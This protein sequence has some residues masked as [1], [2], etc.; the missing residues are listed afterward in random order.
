MLRRNTATYE[1][2]RRVETMKP[3]FRGLGN[4]LRNGFALLRKAFARPGGNLDRD[5]D[6]GRDLKSQ[7]MC[8]SC[9]LITSSYKACCLECGKTLKPA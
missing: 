8:P 7:R 5:P 6:L 9:G 2:V 1:K 3:V 4:R